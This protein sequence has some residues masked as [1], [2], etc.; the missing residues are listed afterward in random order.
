MSEVARVWVRWSSVFWIALAAWGCGQQS[1]GTDTRTNW[2]MA[3]DATAQCGSEFACLCGVC[4]VTCENS[5]ACSGLGEGAACFAVDGCSGVSTVCSTPEVEARRDT[6]RDAGSPSQNANS[7]AYTLADAARA[8]TSDDST[9]TDRA[10]DEATTDTEVTNGT[11]TPLS[12]GD[13]SSSQN[14]SANSGGT[15]TGATSCSP[16]EADAGLCSPGAVCEPGDV[17]QTAEPCE[18]TGLVTRSC[19][20]GQWVE[21]C[22][23]CERVGFADPELERAVRDTL[24]LETDE[25]PLAYVTTMATLSAGNYGISDLRG[26]ECLTSLDFVDLQENSLSDLTPLGLLP[27]VRTLLLTQNEIED[28]TPLATLSQLQELWIS[29]NAVTSLTPVAQLANLTVL[30]I[31][32]NAVSDLEPL[33][34]VMWLTSLDVSNN[35][36]TSITPL[37]NRVGL[38]SLTLGPNPSFDGDLSPI[39]TFT[40]L[41]FLMLPNCGLDDIEVASLS[42]LIQI[43]G[44]DLQGNE[45]VDVEAFSDFSTTQLLLYDNPI[46]CNSASLAALEAQNF[47]TYTDCP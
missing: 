37:T 13:A 34:S 29:N 36:I 23:S 14:S 15:D 18:I 10:G 5:A 3:C 27:A 2:L 33:R 46:D 28:L 22:G 43:T 42:G 41:E 31:G 40:E 9:A 35:P 30:V 38:T 1:T 45:I 44:L 21:T 11:D 20:E 25:L 24:L 12:T 4:T 17:Q 7:G 19:V 8:N 39:S 26:I 16:S 47:M 6:R 32:S